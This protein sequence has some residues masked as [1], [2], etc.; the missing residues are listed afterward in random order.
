MGIAIPALLFALDQHLAALLPGQWSVL[1]CCF[2]FK[3]NELALKLFGAVD[4]C[5][6]VLLFIAATG[7]F[8][9]C[10]TKFDY[11]FWTRIQQDPRRL[12][13]VGTLDK[14][15]AGLGTVLPNSKALASALWKGHC[16]AM[17]RQPHQQS[18]PKP[19]LA[20][21]CNWLPADACVALFLARRAA[22]LSVDGC[23]DRRYSSL[24]HA[25]GVEELQLP[26][27]V[28]LLSPISHAPLPSGQRS[29]HG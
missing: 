1:F 11:P 12:R 14:K 5:H 19:F 2:F 29:T 6:P 23:A 13:V 17:N 9:P 3:R 28:L 16:T 25:P 7:Q 21:R 4:K 20:T 15:R 18:P 10:Q 24:D 22:L 26:N 8:N 27:R